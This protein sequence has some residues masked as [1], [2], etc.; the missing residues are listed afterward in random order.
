MLRRMRKEIRTTFTPTQIQAIEIALVPRTHPIDVRLTLPFLGKG[1][2]CVFLAGPNRRTTNRHPCE[3]T[4]PVGNTPIIKTSHASY[5]AC[6]NPKTDRMLKRMPPEISASFTPIQIRAI[7]A[8][9]VPRSHV[10]DVRLSLPFLGKGA[11][12][13]LAAG[14]NRR[15]HYNNIQNGNPF[16]MPAVLGSVLMSALTILGLVHLKGS[17]LLKAPDPVFA[18]G[19]AFYPTVVPFKKTQ[20]ECEKSDRQW[21]DDQ[22]VDAIHDPIF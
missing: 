7:E 13:V 3:Q 19:E 16:V 6:S 9:L 21:I 8:A 14:P 1:A 2:Y 20:Q 4:M 5:A 12:F 18:Q 22:C 15:A 11:Y 10:I 17:Q